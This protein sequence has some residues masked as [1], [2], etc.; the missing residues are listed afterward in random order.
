MPRSTVRHL[1]I[2]VVAYDLA[3]EGT[4]KVV[5]GPETQR[6]CAGAVRLFHH[7]ECARVVVP[8]GWSKDYQVIMGKA[9]M[10]PHL[11]EAGIPA[12]MIDS[13]VATEFD[14]NSESDTFAK[15]VRSAERDYPDAKHEHTVYVVDRWHHL[16]RTW[17]LLRARLGRDLRTRVRI[18]GQPVGS[19]KLWM[20]LYEVAA[21]WKNRKKLYGAFG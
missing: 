2:F 16:P 4:S 10:A 8:A 20:V 19:W 3:H 9:V 13:P 1:W 5:V 15:H 7:L 17:L 14:T 21:L 12:S 11:K 6:T 18:H